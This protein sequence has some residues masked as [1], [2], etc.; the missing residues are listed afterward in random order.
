MKLGGVGELRDP[1]RALAETRRPREVLRGDHR[2]RSTGP[3]CSRSLAAALTLTLVMGRRRRRPVGRVVV[4]AP[5]DLSLVDAARRVGAGVAA[6]AGEPQRRRRRRCSSH[7]SLASGVVPSA[8]WRKRAAELV[9][10]DDARDMVHGMLDDTMVA[11]HNQTFRTY[12]YDGREYRAWNPA[13]VDANVVLVRGA[14][15]AAAAIA[16]PWVDERLL[17]IGLRF[18]TSGTSS[19]E[20]RDERL[21]NTAA[22]AL[23]SR[24]GPRRDRG[25][26]AHEGDDRQ[27]ERVQADREGAGGRG[28]A[29][30]DQP[31]RAA[32]ARGPDVRTRRRRTARDRGRRPRRGRGDRWRRRPAHLARAGRTRDRDRARR[33]RRAEGSGRRVPRTRRRSCARRSGVER[34]RIED[35]FTEDREWAASDWRA[36][37]SRAPADGLD[38]P[39]A[40]LDGDP[41]RGAR[42]GDR[43]G[44][45][46]RVRGRGRVNGRHR[47]GR[48]HPPVASHRRRPRPTSPP[49]GRGSSS[50]GFG[51]RSS[52]PS[53]RSTS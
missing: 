8:A 3:G 43:D 51:S 30:G 38:R 27:P 14:M 24:A 52:R 34:G 2:P 36:Q 45:R 21:A 28:R 39:A 29:R 37:V 47:R 48:P 23:G 20:V 15:W 17:E 31:V 22:A 6:P 33:D 35:L 53:A 12:H 18:G 4:S 1:I 32:G 42:A 40:D 13:L 19:N 25:A 46:R 16:E 7:C 41:R 9:A 10:A 11:A 49:G 50:A 44:R 5:V 26:R